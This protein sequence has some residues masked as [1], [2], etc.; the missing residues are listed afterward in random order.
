MRLCH[1]GTQLQLP[2]EDPESYVMTSRNAICFISASDRV[3][4]EG[5]RLEELG[6]LNATP[7]MATLR[8]ALSEVVPT[9]WRA[10]CKLCLSD[11][12]Q[13]TDRS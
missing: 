4:A 2:R 1:A 10:D 12:S 7:P 9:R 6:S 8:A 13:S 11:Y 3:L 5:Q